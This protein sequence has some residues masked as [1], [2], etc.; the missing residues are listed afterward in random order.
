MLFVVISDISTDEQRTSNFFHLNAMVLLGEI[1][2]APLSSL[3][4]ERDPWLP[5]RLGLA[6]I[7]LSTIVVVTAL[8]ETGISRKPK[9]LVSSLGENFQPNHNPDKSFWRDTR[10]DL[11][12]R[13]K[14]LH[15][16]WVSPQLI[17]L[18][19]V[20][21]VGTL[22]R[23]SSEFLLQ[24]VSRRYGWQIS[25]AGFLLSYRAAINL[26]LLIGILPGISFLLLRHRH[27]EAQ[28]KDLWLLRASTI[29]MALGTFA[30]GLAPN[31]SLMVI[32]ITLSALGHGFVP[33]LLSLSTALVNQAHIGRLYNVMAVS[34]TLGTLINGPLLAKS[35][36]VG[37]EAGGLLVGLPFIVTG[38]IFLLASIAV[39]IVRLPSTEV[40]VQAN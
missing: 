3:L 20:F 25:Q 18:V 5:A 30:T 38:V 14:G 21:S 23:S 17:L 4:M 11:I 31:A 28:M 36:N 2:L 29:S 19:A 10:T 16:I 40:S 33:V 32:G 26:I 7:V 8:P 34:E 24:Y 12:S 22:Y 15:F 37:M 35:F 27:Y 9:I 13:F 1:F 39:F 6:A